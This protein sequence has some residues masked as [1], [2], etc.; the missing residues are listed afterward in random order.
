[1]LTPCDCFDSP[2]DRLSFHTVPQSGAGLDLGRDIDVAN[3]FE[4]DWNPQARDIHGTRFNQI[5]GPH[6][7]FVDSDV[8]KVLRAT[9]TPDVPQAVTLTP[10]FDGFEITQPFSYVHNSRE[11]SLGKV[12]VDWTAFLNSSPRLSAFAMLESANE[13]SLDPRSRSQTPVVQDDSVSVSSDKIGHQSNDDSEEAALLLSS[14]DKIKCESL[15]LSGEIDAEAT[16]WPLQLMKSHLQM[17]SDHS[18]LE[19]QLSNGSTLSHLRALIESRWLKLEVENMLHWSYEASAKTSMQRKS[20]RAR[21]GPDFNLDDS[22]KQANSGLK[23]SQIEKESEGRDQLPSRKHIK[24][25]SYWL[26]LVPT[27]ALSIRLKTAIENPSTRPSSKV[28]WSLTIT[29]MPTATNRSKGVSA[30][31]VSLEGNDDGPRIPPHLSTFNL[32][33]ENSPIIEYVS[34]NDIENVRRIFG[35]GEA[36]ARDV[37]PWGFSLLSVS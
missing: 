17:L 1:M 35:S 32:V 8:P 3:N 19:W 15:I 2:N 5:A 30:R 31:F 33:P 37:D 7:R 34:S 12:D 23:D 16:I 26:S 14:C 27:G 18:K 25:T 10:S 6:P 4:M 11:A 21:C 36:S 9:T 29:S 22:C 20:L 28:P 13:P 24:F